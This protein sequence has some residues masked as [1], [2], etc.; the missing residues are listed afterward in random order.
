MRERE[1]ARRHRNGTQGQA[2]TARACPSAHPHGTHM[3]AQAR[4]GA[5]QEARTHTHTHTY[6]HY[7][8]RRR[9]NRV[10]TNDHAA[11]QTR[12]IDLSLR[13]ICFHPRRLTPMLRMSR[14]HA[15]WFTAVARN[16]QKHAI[17]TRQSA[18]RRLA[19]ERSHL[20]PR[21]CASQTAAPPPSLAKSSTENHSVQETLSTQTSEREGAA[22][23]SGGCG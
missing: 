23:T 19:L 9:A 5:T 7:I 11:L 21:T 8:M 4:T 16:D 6:T 20:Q 17:T 18:K 12:T 22:G 15:C 10:H 1:H 13:L 3:R 14:S 2:R